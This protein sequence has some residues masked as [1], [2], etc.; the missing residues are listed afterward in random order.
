MAFIPVELAPRLADWI[1]D[2]EGRLFPISGRHA[3]RVI[4]RMADAAGIP[5]ASAHALRHTLATRVYARTG[6]LGVVQRVLGHA[7]VAT[8]VRYARVEEE[9]MRRAVGA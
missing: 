4:E 1:R 8:T 3:Q 5:G 9:A 2:R 7:S 6:D